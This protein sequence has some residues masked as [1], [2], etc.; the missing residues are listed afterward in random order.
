MRPGILS[1]RHKSRGAG[2]RQRRRCWWRARS[3]RGRRSGQPSQSDTTALT[4]FSQ[5]TARRLPARLA[6]L[7]STSYDTP[8]LQGVQNMDLLTKL[9]DDMKAA[10][11]SGQK[12]RLG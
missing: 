3:A 2:Q 6:P 11:K 5:A 9:Q 4:G 7:F 1:T 8:N 12:D 10:M